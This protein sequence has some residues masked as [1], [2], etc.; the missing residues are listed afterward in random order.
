MKIDW[1]LIP[2]VV[3]VRAGSS[4][5]WVAAEQVSFARVVVEPGTAFDG[6][7]HSH[8]HEQWLVMV[9]GRL[10]LAA[11]DEEFWVTPGEVVFFRPTSYHGA[12]G[13]GNEGAEYYEFF[14]PARYDQ[15]PGW[16][17]ASPLT[18]RDPL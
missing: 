10:L 11:G 14:S 13:V 18:W 1:E 12:I 7:L 17:G 16:L 9:R 4:R 8:V 2:T 15:F 6:R 3:G 5:Q